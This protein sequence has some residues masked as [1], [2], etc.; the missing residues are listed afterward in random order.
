[1]NDYIYGF[2]AL[3]ARYSH[4]LGLI[5]VLSFGQCSSMRNSRCELRE[6]YD[7]ETI[8]GVTSPQKASWT[9]LRL[10]DELDS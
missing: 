10:P 6:A 2:I 3:M 4:A 7:A 1:M 9:M 8:K 5:A